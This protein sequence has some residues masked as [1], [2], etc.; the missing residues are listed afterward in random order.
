MKVHKDTPGSNMKWESSRFMM[1]EHVTALKM[2]EY[3]RMK[4]EKPELDEQELQE[5]GIVVMDALKHEL[6][7][8]IEYWEDGYYKEIGGIVNLVDMQFRKIKLIV[9][10]N[11]II[12]ISFDCLLH[13]KVL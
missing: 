10:D 11:D 9:H 1:P 8:S 2:Q 7:V 3:E 6:E 12:D 5:I 4:V 13:A